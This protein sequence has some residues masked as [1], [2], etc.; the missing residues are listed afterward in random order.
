ML[1]KFKS[2]LRDRRIQ[3]VQTCDT[4]LRNCETLNQNRDGN[5][6]NQNLVR[7]A[8]DFWYPK[9][10]NDGLGAN[11]GKSE[12]FARHEGIGMEKDEVRDWK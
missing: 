3:G 1:S 11:E 7:Y 9:S 2:P 10:E 12:L 6:L 5:W 4:P 8:E